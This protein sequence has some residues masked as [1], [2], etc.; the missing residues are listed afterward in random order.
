MLMPLDERQAFAEQIRKRIAEGDRVIHFVYEPG[1]A[2]HYELILTK[3]QR[4]DRIAAGVYERH[5]GWMHEPGRWL[6]AD[7]ENDR[8]MTVDLS[9]GHYTDPSYI[10]EKL[11]GT[12]LGSAVVV[13]ELLNMVNSVPEQTLESMRQTWPVVFGRVPA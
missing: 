1:D 11:R 9:L 4:G 5:A 2:T 7:A 8:A 10:L 13:A 3:Y 6:L 12:T